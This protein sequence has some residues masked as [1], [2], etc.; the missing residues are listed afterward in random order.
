MIQNLKLGITDIIINWPYDMQETKGIIVQSLG[1]FKSSLACAPNHPLASA[2]TVSYS[3]LRKYPLVT[4]DLS[5][6]PYTYQFMFNDWAQM[7]MTALSPLDS[8]RISNMD[9]LI[10]E[11]EMNQS[12]ALIPEFM[13][14]K[15][16]DSLVYLDL[17]IKNPPIFRLAAGY[18]EDNPNPVLPLAVDVLRDNR[19]P[20]SY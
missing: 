17:D 8:K 12:I 11:L 7:G 9:E 20:L 1:E 2:K 15:N 16:T 14:N 4:I 6:M 3:D 13:K 5:K 18:L 10:L 19:I